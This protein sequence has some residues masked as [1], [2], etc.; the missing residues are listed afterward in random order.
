MFISAVAL[1]DSLNLRRLRVGD[2]GRDE[3]GENTP[4]PDSLSLENIETSNDASA[5]R[6]LSSCSTA[7][8]EPGGV[9]MLSRLESGVKVDI[10]SMSMDG[11]A[12]LVAG[13][14]GLSFVEAFAASTTPSVR[15]MR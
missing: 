8:G 15:A 14:T 11:G 9:P 5:A 3:A 4:T 6:P 7:R 12:I 2:P 10:S 1:F 13:T